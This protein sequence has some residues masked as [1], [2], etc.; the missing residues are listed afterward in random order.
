MAKQWKSS[1]KLT[2]LAKEIRKLEQDIGDWEQRVQSGS[3]DP[4]SPSA[5]QRT[6]ENLQRS[7]MTDKVYM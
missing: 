4:Q 3:D 5:M 1:G 7:G 2:K 6:I